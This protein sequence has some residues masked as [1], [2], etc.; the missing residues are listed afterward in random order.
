MTLF[1][2]SRRGVELKKDLVWKSRCICLAG[3]T[4]KLRCT[5]SGFFALTKEMPKPLLSLKIAIFATELLHNL[6]TIPCTESSARR[7]QP[8]RRKVLISSTERK[9]Y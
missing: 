5:S 9:T 2:E 4:T 6:R 7:H 3:R 8:M 1:R